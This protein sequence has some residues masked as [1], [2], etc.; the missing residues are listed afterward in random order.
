M[1]LTFTQFFRPKWQHPK[2]GVRKKA[3]HHLNPEQASDQQILQQLARLDQDTDVRCSALQKLQSPAVLLDIAQSDPMPQ[4][5]HDAMSLFC[6]QICSADSINGSP[7]SQTELIAKI[8]DSDILTHIALNACQLETQLHA[9][10]RINIDSALQQ[11]VLNADNFQVRQRAANAISEPEVL[12]RLIKQCRN[13]DKGVYKILRDIREQQKQQIRLQQQQ[14]NDC[15]SLCQAAEKLAKEQA[16][17]GYQAR[18]NALLQRW[19]ELD[20]ESQQQFQ[21]RFQQASAQCEQLLQLFL[22]EKQAQQA[23]L[24]NNKARRLLIADLKHFQASLSNCAVSETDLQTALQLFASAW[25]KL[26]QLHADSD[27]QQPEYNGHQKNIQLLLNSMQR[28]QH[29]SA[30]I[31]EI[32]AA[33]GGISR[34][35]K[36]LST[37]DWPANFPTPDPVQQLQQHI[38]TLKD[39]KKAAADTQKETQQQH[40]QTLDQLEQILE[41]GK[42]Q[43]AAPLLRQ[44][45]T[46]ATEQKEQ[47]NNSQRQQHQRLNARYQE[48]NNWQLYATRPKLEQLCEAMETLITA[49]LDAGERSS[50]LKELQQQWKELDSSTIPRNLRNRF[51]QANKKAF[52]PCQAHFDE[53]KAQRQNNLKQRQQLLEI[54]AKALS[55]L[56]QDDDDKNLKALS[57]STRELKQEWRKHAPVDRAPG[58]K[59]QSQ[60]NGLLAQVDQLLANDQQHNADAKA[61]LLEQAKALLTRDELPEA[62]QQAKDLQK[63]WREIGPAQRKLEQSL[64]KDFRAVCNE[65]FERRAQQQAEKA[66]QPKIAVVAEDT[67]WMHIER[68]HQLCEQLEMLLLTDGKLQLNEPQIDAWK[69]G[70]YPKAP[71]NQQLQQRFQLLQ[72]LQSDPQAVTEVLSEARQQLRLL[73]IRK[74]IL[75]AVQTPEEDQVL[76]MEYQM[77]HL[78]EA[79]EQHRR[80]PSSEELKTLEKLWYCTPFNQCHEHLRDRFMQTAD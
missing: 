11:V 66:T 17:D 60:F 57:V 69:Q 10:V 39:Q 8:N 64:W 3:I 20:K 42:I 6:R 38:D 22:T 56:E 75:T 32:L 73:C 61:A 62:L 74:E 50:Q 41:Q 48:L 24:Q 16:V 80:T 54:L 70:S 46:I 7:Q 1:Q 9:V 18:L 77:Q 28:L 21:I 36:L 52:A 5:R 49:D 26:N 65:L 59:L 2:P 25:G 30:A 45:T 58:K 13:K 79:L 72:E 67:D 29:H 68:R 55:D 34:A 12:D 78:K 23:L 63:Q 40:Q 76:R 35:R 51:Q 44:L 33:T 71:F 47:F 19:Q 43:Q 31:T 14:R 27:N 15:E 4:V 37:I 53:Q